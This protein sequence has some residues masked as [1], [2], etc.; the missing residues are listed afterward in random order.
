MVGSGQASELEEDVESNPP[1]KGNTKSSAP[2]R[3]KQ[4]L[5]GLAVI[6][7]ISFQTEG[8]LIALDGGILEAH[9][10]SRQIV[11]LGNSSDQVPTAMV[12]YLSAIRNRTLD[13]PVRLRLGG[14]SMDS[15]TYVPDQSDIIEFTNPNANSNDQPVNYG[16][17]LFDV[18]NAVNDKAG[19]T[20]YLIGIHFRRDSELPHFTDRDS[21]L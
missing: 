12:N 21:V 8:C 6:L 13:K 3:S 7:L 14:N 15:S 17:A 11:R 9:H 19:G 18:M 5:P 2:S 4:V 20:E 1:R 10:R 16:P